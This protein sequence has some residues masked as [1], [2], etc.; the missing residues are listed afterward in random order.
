MKKPRSFVGKLITRGFNCRLVDAKGNYLFVDGKYERQSYAIPVAEIKGYGD[1]GFNVEVYDSDTSMIDLY[2]KGYSLR[3]VLDKA[4]FSE[5][6][7]MMMLSI[8]VEESQVSLL[9]DLLFV[10][11]AIGRLPHYREA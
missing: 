11:R 3:N 7:Q 10:L 2:S 9:I 8:Y 6:S 4:G 1:V 5:M